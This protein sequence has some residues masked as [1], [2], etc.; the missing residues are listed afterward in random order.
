MFLSCVVSIPLQKLIFF[1]WQTI[2]DAVIRMVLKHLQKAAGRD[3]RQEK[4]TIHHVAVAIKTL[5]L[6]CEPLAKLV[7]KFILIENTNL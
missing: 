3:L 1:I 2:L 4:E 7:E 5:I 6:N